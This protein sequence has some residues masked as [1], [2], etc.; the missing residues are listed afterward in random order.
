MYSYGQRRQGT[1]IQ[2]NLRLLIFWLPLYRALGARI[3]TLA[4]GARFLRLYSVVCLPYE[5]IRVNALW[6]SLIIIYTLSQTQRIIHRNIYGRVVLV[7]VYGTEHLIVFCCIMLWIIVTKVDFSWV[8]IDT[9][10]F[11][12][13]PVLTPIEPHVHGF[14][15]PLPDG[16]IDNT[17]RC[18]V[19][20]LYW[21]LFALGISHLF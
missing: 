11:L 19:I 14:G 21:N 4:Q 16:I 8:T 2:S 5:S 6:I 10:K 9:E 17:Y 13:T 12:W 15:A 20:S 1:W 7:Q 3:F 18:V